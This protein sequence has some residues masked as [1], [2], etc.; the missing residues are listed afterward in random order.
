MLMRLQPEQQQ[1]QQQQQLGAQLG[2]QQQLGGTQKLLGDQLLGS[3]QFGAQQ[4]AAS[5]AASAAAGIDG[6]AHV[7]HPP[8]HT[9]EQINGGRKLASIF[10]PGPIFGKSPARRA[11]DAIPLFPLRSME[12]WRSSGRNAKIVTKL[13][14]KTTD[15]ESIT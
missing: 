7:V 8:G 11:E 12:S 4:L 15:N 10:K 5:T 1:V 3:Q 13:L 6:D 2:E 14:K 9:L